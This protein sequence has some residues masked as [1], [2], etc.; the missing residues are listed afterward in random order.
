MNQLCQPALKCSL[1]PAPSRSRNWIG[2]LAFPP[3]HLAL[4]R[5]MLRATSSLSQVR[6]TDRDCYRTF[7][8][9]MICSPTYRCPPRT[10]PLNRKLP[11]APSLQ[12]IGCRARR[13]QTICSP[14]CPCPPRIILLNRNLP[15]A[16]S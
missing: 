6:V 8:C 7:P 2:Y 4:P 12:A 3:T 1:L 5:L 15:A 10:M 16:P 9:P 13:L 14:T 11:P